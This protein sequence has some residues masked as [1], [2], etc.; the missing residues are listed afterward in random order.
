MGCTFNAAS[1]VLNGTPAAGISGTYPL[2]FRA[3]NGVD[4]DALQT[5]SLLVVQGSIAPSFTSP[6]SATFIVG[7][8]GSFVVTAAGVP[9]PA[10]SE[11]GNL[12]MGVTF[13]IFSGVLSG[14]PAV[15]TT[16]AYPITFSAAD[17][18]GSNAVQNFTL[19]VTSAPAIIAQPSSQTVTVSQAATFTVTASGA[20]PLSYQWQK[21]GVN[22]L[23]TNSSTYTTPA[24]TVADDGAQYAVIVGNSSGSASSVAV[25]LTVNSPLPLRG[26]R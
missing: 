15:G 22:I 20:A 1:G 7:T 6:S 16:G 5:F 23:G 26:S 9:T 12:P 18:V 19:M 11:T 21:N 2:T 17:G 3:H 13:N 10:L 24:T 14:T 4:A 8:A 25:T